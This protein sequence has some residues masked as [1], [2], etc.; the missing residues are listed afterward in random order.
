MTYFYC[1]DCGEIFSE[2]GARVLWDGDGRV[3][4]NYYACPSCRS[5]N[6]EDASMCEICG[7]PIPHDKN[8]CED[9][10]QEMHKA[11]VGMVEKVMDLRLKENNGLSEDFIDCEEGVIEFLREIGVVF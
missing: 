9:C 11:W 2:E 4:T 6:I 1:E 3:V 10:L 7:K 5:T 8:I